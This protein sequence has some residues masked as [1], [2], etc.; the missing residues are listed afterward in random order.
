M[1]ALSFILICCACCY[2]EIA[3]SVQIFYHRQYIYNDAVVP[4]GKDTA[5]LSETG[6]PCPGFTSDTKGCY[7]N[8]AINLSKNPSCATFHFLI[9]LSRSTYRHTE[10]EVMEAHPFRVELLKTVRVLWKTRRC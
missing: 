8:H 9:S 2:P 6:L 5:V 1:H 10:F 4:S 3:L 7:Q